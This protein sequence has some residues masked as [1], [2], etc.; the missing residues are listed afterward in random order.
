MRLADADEAYE[1]ENALASCL[2]GSLG[3]GQVVELNEAGDVQYSQ[4]QADEKRFA[5]RKSPHAGEFGGFSVH[6]GVTVHA[7]DKAGRERFSGNMS[8]RG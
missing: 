4:E 7:A 6:A 1:N 2:R 8:R 3:I 5:L